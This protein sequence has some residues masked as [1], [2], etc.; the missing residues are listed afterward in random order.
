MEAR[1]RFGAISPK[2]CLLGQ[3][4][5]DTGCEYT[6]GTEAWGIVNSLAT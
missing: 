2:L 1:T 5:R 3:K 4:D 6:T